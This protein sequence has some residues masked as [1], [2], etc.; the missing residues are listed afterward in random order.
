MEKLLSQ[1]MTN[2]FNK[3]RPG[4]WTI[5]ATIDLS[6]AFYYVWH[7]AFSHKLISAGLPPCF[8]RWTQSFF[9]IGALA[10]FIKI[11]KVVFFEFVQVFREDPFL[12]LYFSLSSSMIS[13][14]LCFLWSAALFALTIWPFGPPLPWRPHNEL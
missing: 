9:L 4:F 6:K 12:A 1:S 14:L 11:T 7:P 3:P 8:A 13:Q 10:W 5:L 2:Q